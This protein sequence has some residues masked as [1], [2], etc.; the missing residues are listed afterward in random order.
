MPTCAGRHSTHWRALLLGGALAPGVVAAQVPDIAELTHSARLS[1]LG[2]AGAGMFDN[3]AGRSLNPALL[4]WGAT[5]TAAAGLSNVE[6]VDVRLLRAGSSWR[7]SRS[8]AVALDVRQR[9]VENLIDDPELAS[10]PSLQV[11]DWAIRLTVARS[12]MRKR[13]VV[14]LSGEAMQST[15][16][17]TKG[18]GWSMNAGAAFS[19]APWLS[20]GAAL[21]RMGP[22]YRWTT[23][24]GEESQSD[25]GRSLVFG[26][27]TRP[28]HRSW[29]TLRVLADYRTGLEGV[30]GRSQ[31]LGAEI[32]LADR[33]AFRAG[34]QQERATG[35]AT[36]RS[37]SAGIGVRL[38][39]FHLDL[40]QDRIG[41]VMGQ[42]TFVE[43]S[44]RR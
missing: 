40:A 4:A 34:M 23:A 3:E 1:A 41:R 39:S 15:V 42:R 11:R 32:S 35:T 5:L 28:F 8:S 43:L 44:M 19:A 16:F 26:V 6:S 13:L 21:L 18:T 29:G 24:L 38:G 37:L 14:G 2:G 27:M 22:G 31:H 36:P 25:L 12:A 20:M 33:V 30:A 7:F 9:R 17:G 10:D